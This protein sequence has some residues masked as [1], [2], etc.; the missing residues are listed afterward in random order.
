[1]HCMQGGSFQ[2]VVELKDRE[3][4]RMGESQICIVNLAEKQ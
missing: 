2:T 4:E 3:I 1:M